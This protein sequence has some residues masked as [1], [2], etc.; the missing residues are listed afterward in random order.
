MGNVTFGVPEDLAIELK[1]SLNAGVFIETGTYKGNTA[2]WASKH[3][4]Q[5][6]TIEL[7]EQRYRKTFS[8]ISNMKESENI[9][10]LHGNSKDQLKYVLDMINEPVVFWLDA[11][12]LGKPEE[13]TTQ[14]DEIPLMQE[15]SVIFDWQQRTGNEC[16]ILIDDARLFLAPPPLPYH[17]EYW[18]SMGDIK[19]QFYKHENWIVNVAK[20]VIVCTPKH[21]EQIVLDWTKK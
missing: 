19:E 13:P 11:H 20:D 5:V 8:R 12:G 21:C 17:P 16:V 2:L 14:E 6:F 7:D 3:F 10:F 18:P 9:V 15:L 4:N 1:K